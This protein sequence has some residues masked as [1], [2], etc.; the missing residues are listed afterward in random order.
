[1]LIFLLIGHKAYLFKFI[2]IFMKLIRDYFRAFLNNQLLI[3]LQLYGFVDR[4]PPFQ[5][6][7]V[8]LAHCV[9]LFL[10]FR[11]DDIRDGAVVGGYKDVVLL[12]QAAHVGE[13][14]YFA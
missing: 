14:E 12:G 7:I 6:H 4:H 13:K 11:D 1:M 9:K 5:Q 10:I 2:E 3:A 8:T